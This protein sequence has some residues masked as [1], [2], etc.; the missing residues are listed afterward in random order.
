MGTEDLELLGEIFSSDFPLENPYPEGVN[1]LP[2][3]R[4]KF[5]DLIEP[6]ILENESL[7]ELPEGRAMEEIPERQKVPV[8]R[9]HEGVFGR[10]RG[11][12]VS[13][14][15]SNF[16]SSHTSDKNDFGLGTEDYF[17]A[18]FLMES[19]FKSGISNIRI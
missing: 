11:L 12:E 5:Q 8:R 2:F 13:Q 10:K 17:L 1:L 15:V 19:D 16:F 9:N 3:S 14:N 6:L 18:L 4:G 7:T